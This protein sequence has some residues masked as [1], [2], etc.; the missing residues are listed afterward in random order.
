VYKHRG[1]NEWKESW[2]CIETNGK[3]TW[4]KKDAYEVKG[5]AYAQDILDDIQV[6]GW[7]TK[8]CE[9]NNHAT[10]FLMRIPIEIRGSKTTK[11]M[12]VKSGADLD[13][14]LDAF[15]TV[16]GKWRLW[17][18]I[19]QRQ[20]FKV[21]KQKSMDERSVEQNLKYEE[22]VEFYKTAWSE[23]LNKYKTQ[24]AENGAQNG[25]TQNGTA[26]Q[27]SASVAS[28]TPERNGTASKQV[29]AQ[30]GLA[31][32]VPPP[33]YTTTAKVQQQQQ[34]HTVYATV[35]K[36][37]EVDDSKGKEATSEIY[38]DEDEGEEVHF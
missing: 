24:G 6:S 12:I 27:I 29:H 32:H 30:S 11:T 35:H 4:K 8:K 33:T 10:P 16:V 22:L 31:D 13:L 7:P 26:Q 25:H 19:K 36:H 1:K 14:W 2:L 20:S 9:Q 23:F 28:T 21:G 34:E 37:N 3:L 5:V 18:T 15:A 17:K 38:G